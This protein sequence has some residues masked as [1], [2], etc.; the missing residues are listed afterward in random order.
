[1]GVICSLLTSAEGRSRRPTKVKT[2]KMTTTKPRAEEDDK[3]D[4]R[5]NIIL[6]ITDD[7]DVELGK[8]R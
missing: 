8:Y 7:Q 6:M 1:M 3:E 5:P 2:P 4:D